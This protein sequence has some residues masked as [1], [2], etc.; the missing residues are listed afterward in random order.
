MDVRVPVT[1]VVTIEPGLFYCEWQSV[2]RPD[3]AED[4]IDALVGVSDHLG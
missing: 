1:K 3:G 2:A 4:K